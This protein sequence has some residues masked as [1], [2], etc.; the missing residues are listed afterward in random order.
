MM[1]VTEQSQY[2]S[3][4]NYIKKNYNEMEL[5]QRRLSTGKRVEFPHQNVTATVNSIYYKTRIDAIDVFQRNIISSKERLD[6]AYDTLG[7]VSDALNRARELTLQASNSTYNHEDRIAMAMEVEQMLELVYDLSLAKSKNEYVFSGANVDTKPFALTYSQ[8]DQFGRSVISGAVYEGNDIVQNREIEDGRYIDVGNPGN[9]SFW[10]SNS[11]ITSTTDASNFIV[12]RDS[13]IMID[14]VVIDIKEGD[15]LETIVERINSAGSGFQAE[16]A[17]QRGEGRVISIESTIPHKLMLEDIEG[18]TVLQDLGIIREGL[19]NS[20]QNNYSPTAIV[21]GKSVFEVLID[22]R[23]AMINNDVAALGSRSLGYIDEALGNVVDIQSE[24]SA[25][26][27]RL[28]RNNIDFSN[29]KF[30]ATEALSK[31]EDVDFS[32][33]VLNFNLWQYAHTASLQTAGRL[34]GRTLMDYLR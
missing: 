25:K 33:E 17:F 34:L 12:Q 31:N 22:A 30:A 8:N 7:S 9:Y 1:R 2:N 14:N 23:D 27:S 19:A 4:V 6:V 10:A 15:N 13:K 16:V 11:Q 3:T 24:V 28:E 26:V 21:E 18:G 20:P 5:A 32:Q 29:Q